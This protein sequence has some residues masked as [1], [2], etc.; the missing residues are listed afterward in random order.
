MKK[1]VARAAMKMREVAIKT[2]RKIQAFSNSQTP[3]KY[4]SMFES[5]TKFQ[6][7]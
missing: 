1:R 6:S 3:K 5:Q 4:E 7:D 2:S